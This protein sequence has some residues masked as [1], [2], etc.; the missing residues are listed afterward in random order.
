[1]KFAMKR[2]FTLTE[3]LVVIA[4]IALL[5]AL[6]LPALSKTRGAARKAVCFTNARQINFAMRMYADDHADAILALT[7]KD[8]I[9]FIPLYW[10]GVT[11]FGNSSFFYE[12]PAGYEYKWSEK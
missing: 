8:A 5:A 4:I 11:G 9:Y 1:M 6:L 2:A 3:L 10:N 12:P 7:N